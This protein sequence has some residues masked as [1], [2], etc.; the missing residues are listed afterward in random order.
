MTDIALHWDNNLQE[1]DI[2]LDGPDLAV[3]DGYFTAVIISLFAD[4][5][6]SADDKIPDGSDDPRGWW[7]DAVA[8]PIGSHLWLLDRAKLTPEN[9]QRSIDYAKAS[10]AWMVD[11]KVAKAV[12][13]TAERRDTNTIA[14]LIQ[15][16]KPD[17]SVAGK[18]DFVWKALK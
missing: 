18:Y 15:I 12:E 6:A 14:I 13:V 5:R 10:L 11:D 9:Q 17:G 7:A 2:A 1:A 8:D 3:D 4:A 16:L